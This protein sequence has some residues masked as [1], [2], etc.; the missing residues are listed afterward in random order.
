MRFKLDIVTGWVAVRLK[1]L[2]ITP[3]TRVWRWWIATLVLLAIVALVSPPTLS[4]LVLKVG[5]QMLAAIIGYH[6][7]KITLIHAVPEHLREVPVISAALTIGRALVML[8]AMLAVGL[9]L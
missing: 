5:Q 4:V 3:L 6:L 9:G 7:A 1:A 8:G 2:G